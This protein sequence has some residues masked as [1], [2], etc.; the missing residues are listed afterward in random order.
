MARRCWA[1]S[2]TPGSRPACSSRRSGSWLSPTSG[3]SEPA[4]RRACEEHRG[5]GSG[6]GGAS[7]SGFFGQLGAQLKP[8]FAVGQRY[9][10]MAPEAILAETPGNWA[11][12]PGQ[13]GS[14]TVE[15]K[16]RPGGEDGP[17]FDFVKITI[18]AAGARARTKRT[19]TGPASERF[20]LCWPEPS[21]PS[22]GRGAPS[23]RQPAGKGCV[24][25]GGA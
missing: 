19:T 25:P 15:R 1:P 5:A 11:L 24:G 17:D 4:H 2:P 10:A 7:G 6:Q 22:S 3:S 23:R 14:I 12:L 21:G 8:S 13:V 18:E 20:R 9:C 16:S